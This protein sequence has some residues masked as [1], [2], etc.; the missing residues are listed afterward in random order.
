MEPVSNLSF[1][2]IKLNNDIAR[3]RLSYSIFANY[4]EILSKTDTAIVNVF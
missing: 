2:S 3:T 1:Q 4:Q